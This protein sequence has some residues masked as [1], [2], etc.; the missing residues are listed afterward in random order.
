M[1][2]AGESLIGWETAP[3]NAGKR[4]TAAFEAHILNIS[5]SSYL[6]RSPLPPIRLQRYGY[7]LV[8]VKTGGETRAQDDVFR[9]SDVIGKAYGSK[10]CAGGH[11][12]QLELSINTSLQLS[13]PMANHSCITMEPRGGLC[14]ALRS[15]ADVTASPSQALAFSFFKGALLG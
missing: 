10:V 2:S 14:L 1:N 15:N 12:A 9:H 6:V 8:T 7:E 5:F 4:Q 11:V 3:G 13:I